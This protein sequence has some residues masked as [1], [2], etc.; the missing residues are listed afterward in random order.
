MRVVEEIEKHH[1]GGEGALEIEAILS[2]HKHWDHSG[3]NVELLEYF[4]EDGLR[5]YGHAVEHGR[6][7]TV[8]LHI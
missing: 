8:V 4:R 7:I 6:N 5:V 2:T 1:Y 3:A